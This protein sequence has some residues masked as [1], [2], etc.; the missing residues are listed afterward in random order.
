MAFNNQVFQEKDFEGLS[1]LG[2]GSKRDDEL[3][4]GKFG[5]GFN[6]V[7]SVT[8]TPMFSSNV[9]SFSTLTF[10]FLRLEHPM[11]QVEDLRSALNLSAT[12]VT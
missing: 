10:S 11:S 7:Y 3:T 9:L 6:T 4:I 1:N 12:T 8:D 5:I 2:I